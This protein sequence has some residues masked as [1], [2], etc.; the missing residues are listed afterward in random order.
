MWELRRCRRFPA[1]DMKCLSCHK[2]GTIR[3][4]IDKGGSQFKWLA[5]TLHRVID[6]CHFVCRETCR[7]ERGEEVMLLLVEQTDEKVELLYDS[8]QN[9]FELPLIGPRPPYYYNPRYVPY[10]PVI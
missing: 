6:L 5:L 4:E 2:T 8:N 1:V 7:D 10:Y 3:S 9:T